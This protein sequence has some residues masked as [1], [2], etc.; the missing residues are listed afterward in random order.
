M[1]ENLIKL[2]E[3]LKG[4]VNQSMDKNYLG[5]VNF[6]IWVSKSVLYLEKEYKNS[7]VTEKIKSH[8]KEMDSSQYYVFYQ[9]LLGSLKALQDFEQKEIPVIEL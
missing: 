7:L 3:A 8:Y 1:L 2:G 5:S 9:M 4:E 6:E